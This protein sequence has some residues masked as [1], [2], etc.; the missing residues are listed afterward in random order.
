[1]GGDPADGQ[2]DQKRPGRG[3]R[4]VQDG[5]ARHHRPARDGRQRGTVQ[6]ERRR[7]VQQALALH[8]RDDGARHAE[9]LRDGEVG[10]EQRLKLPVA[11]R[12]AGGTNQRLAGDGVGRREDRAE[13]ERDGEVAPDQSVDRQPDGP[14]R[15][16]D[17]A[18]RE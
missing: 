10:R 15:D 16:E 1:M 9:A 2:P 7:V 12:T 17:E 5:D 3:K 18:D 8:D 6:R 14:G 13:D 11:A 4:E